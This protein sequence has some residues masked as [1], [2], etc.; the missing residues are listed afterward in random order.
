MTEFI[1]ELPDWLKDTLVLCAAAFAGLICYGLLRWLLRL[2]EPHAAMFVG[3]LVRLCRAPARLLLP[4]IGFHLALPFTA[5]AGEIEGLKHA[6]RIALIACA[7]WL[8]VRLVRVVENVIAAKLDLTSVDN[9]RA[10]SVQTQFRILRNV[11]V[12]LVVALGVIGVLLSIE[13]FRELGAGLLASAGIAS[14]VIGLAAQ[15]TLGN[16]FAGFQIA[17][18]QPIRFDDVLV[19][20]GQWGRVEEITLTYVVLRSWD[21]RR[22][23]VPIS[24]FLEK[25]FENWTRRTANL[26]GPVLL[27]LDYTVDVAVVRA[28]LERIAAASKLWDGDVCALQVT[29]ADAQS[30]ELRALVSARN[31]SEVWD[32]RCEVREKLITFIQR[33]YPDALPRMR[34]SIDRQPE[35][36]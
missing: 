34:T 1:I 6:S 35:E 23:V 29:D 4:L 10:R 25:P 8:I 27:Y 2:A 7:T 17:L 9:L 22:L 20:E 21:L 5:V 19:V 11:V 18:T 15:R 30:V 28:E 36:E 3:S 31:S 16:L 32:L 12:S 26:L 13:R 24:Y 14:I 33:E